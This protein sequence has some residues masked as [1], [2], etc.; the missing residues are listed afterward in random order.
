MRRTSKGHGE[1]PCL[2]RDGRAKGTRGRGARET[3]NCRTSLTFT[4]F[5]LFL[6]TACPMTCRVKSCARSSSDA[7]RLRME[8]GCGTSSPMR[9]LEEEDTVSGLDQACCRQR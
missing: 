6:R 5:V 8:L 3:G 9:E 4:M 1:E 7:I 2:D